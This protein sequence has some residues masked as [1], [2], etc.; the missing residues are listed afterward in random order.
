M[1]SGCTGL[2][3][4]SALPATT[5]SSSC[6]N[7]MFYGCTSLTITPELP[8][9]TLATYCYQYMFY[10]CTSLTTAP[11]LP[12][13]TLVTY[14]Y[15]NMFYGCRNLN[16]IKCLATDISANSCT[17]NWVTNVASTGTF[18]KADN[19]SSWTVDSTSGIPVGWTVEDYH[20]YSN[21]YLTFD[22][23][24]SGDIVWKKSGGSNTSTISYSKNDGTWTDI[25]S[26]TTG[27]SISVTTGDKVKFKGS[28]SVYYIPGNYYNCF[29]GTATFDAY[30][31]IMSLIG[32]DNFSNLTTLSS[33]YNFYGLFENCTGLISAENIILPATT[34][35]DCCYYE[36]FYG[37]TNLT[38]A[39]ALPATTLA[40]KCYDGMF[41]GCTSLTTAPELPAI[42]LSTDCYMGMFNGCTSLTTAPALPATTLVTN[43]YNG[44]FSD[45][46]SLNYI[47]CLATNISATSCTTD[48]V[49]RVAST[50]TFVKAASMAGWTTG[51]DG[52]PSGWTVQDA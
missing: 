13:T 4:A 23:K 52:I 29:G 5:L 11:T 24:S 15:Y 46:I 9:T 25:T 10:G 21:D 14:C 7:H 31:N 1:F 8:A 36:M 48:W 42:T 43:C 19:M 6:Y 45:C 2:T 26:D 3:T 22:I 35:V 30:G 49:G 37:C 44:M 39:P 32:G 16:Y 33:D 12:A 20:D 27:V 51:R 50:G 38:T 40:T 28:N 41:K 34:L 17:S 18:V 47:K